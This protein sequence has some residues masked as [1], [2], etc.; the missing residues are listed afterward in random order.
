MVNYEMSFVINLYLMLLI[1]VLIRC[2]GWIVNFLEL[3]KAPQVM[4]QKDPN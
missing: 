2:D 1:S 4:C 3:N